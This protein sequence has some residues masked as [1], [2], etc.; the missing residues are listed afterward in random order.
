VSKTDGNF[1]AELVGSPV[2]L[3]LVILD[4]EEWIKERRGDW[5]STTRR[6]LVGHS[7]FD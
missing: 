6:L 5:R 7:D 1:N 2:D 3:L 4:V